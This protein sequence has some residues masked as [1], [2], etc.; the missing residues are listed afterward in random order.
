MSGRLQPLSIHLWAAR[1]VGAGRRD[2][3]GRLVETCPMKKRLLISALVFA[4]LLLAL[5]GVMFG[6]GAK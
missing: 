3:A 4:A 6:T 1:Q 5:Y 2:A